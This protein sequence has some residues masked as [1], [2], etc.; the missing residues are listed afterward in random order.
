MKY[1]AL[2]VD[3][4]EF[5]NLRCKPLCLGTAG[6]TVSQTDSQSVGRRRQCPGGSQSVPTGQTVTVAEL[7]LSKISARFSVCKFLFVLK[8][9][10]TNNL[11]RVIEFTFLV[12]TVLVRRFIRYTLGL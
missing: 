4:G 11:K 9:V 7:R 6:L 3:R 10:E 1:P 8:I 5:G 12:E 2:A